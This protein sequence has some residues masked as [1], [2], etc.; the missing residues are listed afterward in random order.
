[1]QKAKPRAGDLGK[2]VQQQVSG[3]AGPRTETFQ[4]P[5]SPALLAGGGERRLLCLCRS[6][7]PRR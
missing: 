5:G 2:V 6:L 3:R 7:G 4:G 1:M